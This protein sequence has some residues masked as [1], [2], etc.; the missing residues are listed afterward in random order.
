VDSAQSARAWVRWLNEN[1]GDGVKVRNGDHMRPDIMAALMDEARRLEMGTVAH[2]DQRGVEHMNAI[3]AARL[4]RRT[5]T[6]FYGHFESLLRPG[7]QLFPPDYDYADEQVRFSQV[8]DWVNKI[9]PVGGSEWNA[10]L[11]EHLQLG[12]VF[13]PTFNIYVA[14][15]DVVRMRTAEW[16][17]RYTLPSL[18]EFF[19]PSPVAHG[20]YYR[21]WGTEV[22]TAW[23]RFYQVWFQL[24]R[25][26]HRMGGRITTGSDSGFIYQTYGF[27]YIME[28]EMLREAGLD[29]LEVVT[30]ATLNGAKTLYEPMGID[31][32]PIGTVTPGKA[33]DLVVAPENPLSD[34]SKPEWARRGGGF[35][36]LYGTGSAPQRADRQARARRRHQV[37]DQGR[38]R[39]RRPPAARGCRRDG[40]APASSAGLPHATRTEGASAHALKH[41]S[42]ERAG[43]STRRLMR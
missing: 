43:I 35:K 38:R 36:T 21:D 23:K 29:P 33:A 19:Q 25:D 40:R 12:T 22:E 18:W 3:Q 20:S 32:P 9:H 2:L 16:H 13:D 31:D 17:D 1:G 14:S 5:V 28:L 37:D 27:A 8:A 39:L 10:Y 41:P 24:V 4:G 42:K 6:H 7:E 11:R 34:L 15:R 30:A 26:Y